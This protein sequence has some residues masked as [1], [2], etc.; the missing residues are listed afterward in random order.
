[1]P[2]YRFTPG[3]GAGAELS[4]R[5]GHMGYH[6]KIQTDT[7]VEGSMNG[8]TTKGR[9]QIGQGFEIGG[10]V[11]DRKILKRKLPEYPA[12]AEEKGISA[13]VVIF[14]TVRPDGS[15]RT[16]M[17]VERSSGYPELDQLAKEALLQWRFSATSASSSESEAWGRITFKFTLN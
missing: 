9:T 15:I 17:R 1:M 10:P 13:M 8:S 3:Q 5:K 16:A 14:F 2:G 11:G 4:D 7:Y 6:G 12:W